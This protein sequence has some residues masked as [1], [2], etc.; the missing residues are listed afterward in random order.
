[1]Q[2]QTKGETPPPRSGHSATLVGKHIYIFG[3]WDDPR[4]YNDMF[5]LDTT[6]NMWRQIHYKGTPPIQRTWHT[7][8]LAY[9]TRLLVFG[10]YDGLQAL[11][12]VHI[13]DTETSTW[14][15][16]MT[17]KIGAR[18]GHSATVMKDKV[19]DLR[20]VIHH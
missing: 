9:G 15:E 6:T 20:F 14:E 11:Q 4:K 7:C 3:G 1:M 12:D 17:P 8:S 10:G 18:A 13:F 19:C 2:L 16:T 5:A